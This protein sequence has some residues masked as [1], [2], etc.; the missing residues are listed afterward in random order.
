MTITSHGRP[1]KTQTIAYTATPA[2]SAAFGS[3]TNRIRLIATTAALVSIG[4][5]VNMY[6]APNFPEI[7]LVSPGQSLT[8]AQ[9]AAPGSICITELE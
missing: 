8:V 7:F 2:T 6:L 9:F 1:G 5:A 4:D 3:Q